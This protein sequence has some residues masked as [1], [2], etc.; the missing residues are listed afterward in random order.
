MIGRDAW[1]ATVAAMP[2]LF[3]LRD[4]EIDRLRGLATIFLHE[5]SLE[6][7]RGLDMTDEMRLVLAAQAALPILNLGIDSYD[8]WYSLV[9]YPEEFIT[10][11]EW[12]DED[13]LMHTRR[14]FLSG[15][16]WD[17]GPMVLSWSDVSV[18]P[19]LDGYNAV[20]HECAHKLDLRNGTA[21]GLP[22]LHAGMDGGLWKEVFSAAYEDMVQR[23]HS[24]EATPLDPYSTESPAEFFAVMSEQFFETPRLLLSEYPEVYR[25]LVMF[26]RQDPVSRLPG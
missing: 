4:D 2:L 1:G 23:V 14:D 21:N 22:P 9:L 5:K 24:G 8:G 15:E 20:I 7:V 3:G 17:R 10:Q 11:H 13:G 6:P 25:Q 26:Y 18:S 16:A 12:M 19:E